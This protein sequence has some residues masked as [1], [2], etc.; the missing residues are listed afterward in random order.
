MP[1]A[2]N[3]SAIKAKQT[4]RFSSLSYDNGAKGRNAIYPGVD[5]KYQNVSLIQEFKALVPPI[6]WGGPNFLETKNWLK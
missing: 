1:R 5:S 6:F 2:R 4:I 3:K